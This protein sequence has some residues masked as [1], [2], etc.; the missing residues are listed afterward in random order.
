[1]P[2]SQL[3]FLVFNIHAQIEDCHTRYNG[4]ANHHQRRNKFSFPAR[5]ICGDCFEVIARIVVFL[6][7]NIIV[8]C[9]YMD[10][11]ALISSL[12]NEKIG[13]Q[14]ANLCSLLLLSG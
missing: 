9:F 6:V 10:M 13:G 8:I 2:A 4:D 14:I 11:S 12:L 3:N 5:L 1:M 7:N